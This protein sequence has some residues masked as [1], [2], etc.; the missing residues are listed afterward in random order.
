MY[1]C[2]RFVCR[3]CLNGS[4]KMKTSDPRLGLLVLFTL[5]TLSFLV[6]YW[7]GKPDLL[8]QNRP[9][10]QR[11]RALPIVGTK[12]LSQRSQFPL[13]HF[14]RI[15]YRR[16]L[17]GSQ[18]MANPLSS[19][20]HPFSYAKALLLN[21]LALEFRQNKLASKLQTPRLFSSHSVET[22]NKNFLQH[23]VQLDILQ[24]DSNSS[25]TLGNEIPIKYAKHV[26]IMTTWRSGSTFLG[27]LLNHYPGTWYS[28]EPLLALG[29]RQLSAGQYIDESLKLVSDVLKCKPETSFYQYASAKQVLFLHNLRFWNTCKN[30]L[31]YQAACFMPSLTEQ[32]C[33]LFPIRLIKLVRMRLETVKKLFEDP[34]LNTLKLVFLI[35]DPRGVMNS[36]ASMDWCSKPECSEPKVL[37]DDL[38]ND[39]LSAVEIKKKYPNKIHIVRY[40]DLCMDPYSQM[41]DILK[42]LNL[43]PKPQIEEILA[44]STK[45]KRGESSSIPLT[46]EDKEAARLSKNPYGTTRVSK[47]TAFAWAKKMKA[48]EIRVI[49]DACSAAMDVFGYKKMKNV[50]Q[51]KTNPN[52]LLIKPRSELNL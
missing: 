45:T 38:Y 49:Q 6:S 39:Y 29:P 34:E 48:S 16:A 13:R 47:L 17:F 37:C 32:T 33:P 4:S 43:P 50:E 51:D 27:N 35:R 15:P 12:I 24:R 44:T 20:E 19:P 25:L 10:L 9:G 36:R 41:D 1:L 28:F 26:L 18:S 2:W 7:N 14:K 22:L 23:P 42:F 52:F 11:G 30:L 8:P 31:G 21:N 46:L 5:G 3:T 40:E